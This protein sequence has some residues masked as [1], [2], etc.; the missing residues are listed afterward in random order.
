[1]YQDLSIRYYELSIK[2]QDPVSG[3]LESDAH[4]KV[5]LPVSNI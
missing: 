2:K 5:L 3:L 4:T 1:M